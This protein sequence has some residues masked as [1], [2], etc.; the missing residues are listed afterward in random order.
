MHKAKELRKPNCL[1]ELFIMI[2]YHETSYVDFQ[3]ALNAY[4]LL[5]YRGKH[6][7]YIQQTS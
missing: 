7:C 2:I 1:D 4:I 6:S 5:G 3:S